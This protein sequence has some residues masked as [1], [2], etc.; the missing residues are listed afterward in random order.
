LFLVQLV[1]WESF[2]QAQELV[3]SLA[4][5]MLKATAGGG[6]AECVG[7]EDYLKRDGARAQESAA[8]FGNDGMALKTDRRARHIEIQG[9]WIQMAMSP[10]ERDCSVQRR[11][12]N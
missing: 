10:S 3:I 4:P 6:G 5:V 11:H 7:D 1:F 8:A 12:Q 9:H 2:E